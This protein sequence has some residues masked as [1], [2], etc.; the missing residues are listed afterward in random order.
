MYTYL[1]NTPILEMR[2]MILMT[3]S[4]EG[5]QSK[6]SR[7]GRTSQSISWQYLVGLQ[8]VTPTSLHAMHKSPT[9]PDD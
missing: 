5:P 7:G 4:I 9:F 3:K 6:T 2:Q 1:F 8:H